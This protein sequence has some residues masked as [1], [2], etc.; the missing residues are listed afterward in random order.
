MVE[1]PTSADEFLLDS[2]EQARDEYGD[3]DF[4]VDIHYYDISSSGDPDTTYR[5]G[6]YLQH[7]PTSILGK[8]RDQK[9]WDQGNLP[10]TSTYTPAHGDNPWFEA[11]PAVDFPGVFTGNGVSAGSTLPVYTPPG[12]PPAASFGAPP[13]SSGSSVQ[14]PRTSDAGSNP[15]TDQQNR[16]G[17]NSEAVDATIPTNG[18]SPG[19]AAKPPLEPQAIPV[20]NPL[21]WLVGAEARQAEFEFIMPFDASRD[22]VGSAYSVVTGTMQPMLEHDATI[23]ILLVDPVSGGVDFRDV[24]VETEL[25]RLQR[26]IA[27]V[28]ARRKK[29]YDDWVRAGGTPQ[30]LL[31]RAKELRKN[32]TAADSDDQI[33]L[34]FLN[35]R[36][37]EEWLQME[38]AALEGRE[39]DSTWLDDGFLDVADS[40]VTD[41]DTLIDVFLQMYGDDGRRLL[42]FA[43]NHGWSIEIDDGT[44]GLRPTTDRVTIDSQTP[45]I[46]VG[47]RAA[48]R[49]PGLRGDF[50]PLDGSFYHHTNANAASGLYSKLQEIEAAE[51]QTKFDT[52]VEGQGW[53]GKETEISNLEFVSAGALYS[54]RYQAV[55]WIIEGGTYQETIEG[56]KLSAGEST[57][58][59]GGGL[60]LTLLE[61]YGYKG[62]S[63]IG[64]KGVT[65]GINAG[66]NAWKGLKIAPRSGQLSVVVRD[67]TFPVEGRLI[68][69]FD[70]AEVIA[71]MS[72]SQLGREVLEAATSNR[73][74]LEF[75][76][77]FFRPGLLGRQ[78]RLVL[79]VAFEGG[80]KA[81]IFIPAHVN[82]AQI[83][84][85][86]IHEGL[87]KLGIRGSQQAEI[88]ARIAERMHMGQPITADVLQ[89]IAE[90][91]VRNP[92]Y[93]NLKWSVGR[94][95]PLFPHWE[96]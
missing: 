74:R 88:I 31:D 70:E 73:I 94:R 2:L 92:R 69:W 96:F 95:H 7:V 90:F 13:P 67:G 35:A 45:S 51:R 29:A 12:S 26:A 11:S 38:L 6:P 54:G 59:V 22:A 16:D 15:A 82:N 42:D 78:D 40:Q 10:G 5:D 56:E 39:Y 47:T 41:T 62:L 89:E 4:S 48:F 20:A 27:E 34:D 17:E 79:G 64:A 66:K 33:V 76:R 53:D 19:E 72:R 52:I 43:Q 28:E 84:R 91:V 9:S 44:Y 55:V 83:A 14:Q 50:P 65:T 60:A 63:Q 87:H 80:K 68:G 61:I 37:E 23:V 86:A 49:S 93:Q 36:N 58:R 8:V 85:T 57:L 18:N 32:P 21:E 75:S 71:D 30:A 1:P 77:S 3:F 81:K 25:E 24:P 46:K